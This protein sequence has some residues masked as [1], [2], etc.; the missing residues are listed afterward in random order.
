MNNNLLLGVGALTVVTL[1]MPIR[2]L[3]LRLHDINRSGWWLLALLLLPGMAGALQ[4]PEL[5]VIFSAL[6]WLAL[7]VLAVWPGD[8]MENDFGLPGSP[9]PM[10]VKA[11]AIGFLVLQV[12]AIGAGAK[13]GR[14]GSAPWLNAKTQER[15]DTP[16]KPFSPPDGSFTIDLPGV[17]K[18]IRMPG[19]KPEGM[20]KWQIYSLLS[21]GRRYHIESIKLKEEPD[22][23]T[24]ALDSYRDMLIPNAQTVVVSENRVRVGELAGRELRLALPT[25][26]VQDIRLLI[27]G[28]RI[29]VVLVESPKDKQ[30]SDK[31]KIVVESFHGN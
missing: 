30:N 21:G 4:K 25:G 10:W 19:T 24:D 2:L 5:L 11:V 27:A 1:W 15:E 14:S 3:V 12:M 6:F 29:F 22:K 7:L 8:A 26:A 13:F 9:N 28:T 18:K 16:L 31:A 17:P 20:E 23:S